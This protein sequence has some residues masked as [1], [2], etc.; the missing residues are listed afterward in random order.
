ME[1][2]LKAFQACKDNNLTGFIPFVTCGYPNRQ[3]TVPLL[4]SLEKAGAMCI[5]LGV[6][7][8]DPQA[9]G[10]TIQRSSYIALVENN[11]TPQDCLD[12]LKE[13]RKEGLRIPV[14]L[15][16]YYNPVFI[17]GEEKFVLA[18][19]KVG[20]N[21]FIVV[22]L[23]VE[24][25]STFRT[26]CNQEKMSLVPLVTPTTTK[27]R[28]KS[29]GQCADTFVYAV[30]RNAVTG[31]MDGVAEG[32]DSYIGRVRKYIDKP[33]AIGFGI[34]NKED[35]QSVAQH[36]DACV[37]GSQV[38]REIEE[39]WKPNEEESVAILCKGVKKY[40]K[41]FRNIDVTGKVVEVGEEGC[42]IS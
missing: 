22:D 35:F 2:V 4:L 34:K 25:A 17:F 14:I 41:Q 23:P 40:A 5:E 38:I 39:N 32:L 33:I 10:E 36:A 9:D 30:S 42:T 16:T 18:A 12:V 15:F 29:I 20:A 31:R 11:I 13:A 1:D 24:E 27:K 6:P 26:V 21:G 37:I 19:K 8:S 28:L 3:V 7:Y